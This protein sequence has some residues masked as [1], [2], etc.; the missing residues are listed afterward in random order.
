M[1]RTTLLLERSAWALLTPTS[2]LALSMPNGDEGRG[3]KRL[4]S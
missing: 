3:G 1:G 4:G 2:A